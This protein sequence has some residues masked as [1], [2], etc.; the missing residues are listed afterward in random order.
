MCAYQLPKASTRLPDADPAVVLVDKKH[1]EYTL[2][3]LEHYMSVISRVDFNRLQES[4]TV[5]RDHS[6]RQIK[7]YTTTELRALA[8]A[9]DIQVTNHN[10]RKREL[11]ELITGNIEEYQ[12][13]YAEL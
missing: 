13:Y 5:G 6:G 2:E 4:Q 7:S 3:Q 10:Y 8:Q 1:H 11:I 12:A 9:L